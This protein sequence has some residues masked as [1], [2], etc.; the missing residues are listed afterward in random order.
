MAR[1]LE[2]R[3]LNYG[4]LYNQ[5]PASYQPPFLVTLDN[6]ISFIEHERG[7]IAM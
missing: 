6:G 2:L 4:L 1:R 3:F 5:L 7:I